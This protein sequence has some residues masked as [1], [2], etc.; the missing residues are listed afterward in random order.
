MHFLPKKGFTLIELLVV[1]AIIGILAGIVLAAL[2][3]TRSQA[4]NAGAQANFNSLRTQAEIY[5]GTNNNSYSG[6]CAD[7]R[8]T[9]ILNS[10]IRASSATPPANIAIGTAGNATTV[11]C[12][13]TVNGWAA[14]AP[15][16]SAPDAM[17]CVDST[18]RAATTTT[19]NV[20]TAND[21]T[22]N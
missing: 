19:A 20:L 16:T 1:I 11:T 10:A 21:I 12:H 13:D 4:M 7:A 2:G 14:E 6:L 3:N 15:L 5:V 9:N 17:W 22:C 8:V 18:G